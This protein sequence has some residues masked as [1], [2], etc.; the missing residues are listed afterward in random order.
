GDKVALR[1]YE[2][3]IVETKFYWLND[4]STKAR[5]SAGVMLTPNWED[6]ELTRNEN[7]KLGIDFF[8]THDSKSLLLVVSNMG[9]LRILE[10]NNKLSHTQY[11]ILANLKSALQLETKEQSHKILWDSLALSEV[12]KKFYA[13]VAEQFNIL[14]NHLISSGKDKEDAKLF[15]SRLLGRLLFVW[16]LRRKRIINED[17]GYFEID[18]EDSTKYYDSKLKKLF[19][20]T[21]NQPIDKRQSF[22]GNTPY[23]NGGLFE[24][25]QN[26]WFNEIV[27]FPSGYFN[28]L[29]NHLEKYNFTTDES[30]PEY[31]QVAIDP[32]ML[33]RVFESLLATQLTE[34]GDQARKAKGAF[35]TPR[36]IVSYMCKES[37]REYLYSKLENETWNEGIDKLLDTTD[38]EWE[39]SHSNSKRNLWGEA[40]LNVVPA[41]VISALDELTILDPA[42]GSG[43]FPMGM[44]QLI[45]R[46]YERLESRF[47]P[48]NT[49]LQIIQNNIYGVDIEPMA[50]EISRLRAWLSLIVDKD[51]SIEPL[52]N[53]DFKFIAANTLIKPDRSF[54][55]D[56]SKQ[57][58]ARAKM[59]TIIRKYFEE[60]DKEEKVSLKEQFIKEESKIAQ[61]SMF[62]ESKAQKQA[63]SYKPFDNQNVAE[64]FDEKL[65]FGMSKTNPFDI[66]IGNP[67]YIQ[68]QKNGGYLANLYNDEDYVTYTRTGDI[69]SLFYERGLE[70]TKKNSGLLCF[71]TSNKWMRAAYG[72]KTRI[73][74]AKKDPLKLI[75]FG[76]FKVFESATVDTNILLIRNKANLKTT[77]ACSFKNDFKIGDSIEGYFKSNIINLNGLGSG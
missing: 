52:P 62:G 17:L 23:L 28:G 22:D 47:D 26:D 76:G 27:D 43:A 20:E 10:L 45:L 34:T 12:N 15:A 61:V 30:S 2:D 50:V 58:N 18:S 38:S 48:Y 55:L 11:E 13:G 67:P 4:T 46:T 3:E 56:E 65:M 71:I 57:A 41:K 6:S 60:T 42:C 35:Y 54:G 25:H 66:V 69:Y 14:L 9:N 40:N 37:L 5:V 44:L 29:Y 68:L 63:Q 75:D 70:L 24:A 19:F 1:F 77:S 59:Q 51:K 53:L 8:L 64:F 21:L 32:E 73:Y 7:Y 49:K 72:E 36:E 39:L 16:F 31:E 33:G 74:L